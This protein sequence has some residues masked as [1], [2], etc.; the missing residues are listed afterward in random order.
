MVYHDTMV[1]ES[2][3]DLM[4][5]GEKEAGAGPAKSGRTDRAG[6]RVIAGHFDE[7]VARRLKILAAY[8]GRSVQSLL[9]EALDLLFNKYRP[10]FEAAREFGA[11]VGT[12]PRA[13]G[14]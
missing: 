8:R 4:A 12:K 9:A 2:G 7:S 5:T 6:K 1:P 3:E 11:S 14:V 10:N 13:P